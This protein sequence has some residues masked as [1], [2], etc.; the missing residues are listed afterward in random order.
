MRWHLGGIMPPSPS[1]CHLPL[2]LN[3]IHEGDDGTHQWQEVCTVEPPPTGLRHVEEL[4]SHQEPL[5]P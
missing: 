5:R 3:A 4:V 1:A 2:W